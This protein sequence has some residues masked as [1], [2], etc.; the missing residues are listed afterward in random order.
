MIICVGPVFGQNARVVIAFVTIIHLVCHQRH[1]DD[2]ITLLSH[3][4]GRILT[5]TFPV[6]SPSL[7]SGS[8]EVREQRDE[9]PTVQLLTSPLLAAQLHGCVH[10]VAALRRRKR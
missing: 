7:C 10:L 5:T 8:P 4:F 6:F 9:H 3:T 1:Q 2:I